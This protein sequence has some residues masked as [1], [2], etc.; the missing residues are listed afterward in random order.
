MLS[1]TTTGNGRVHA[2]P[3]PDPE[4]PERPQERV[5]LRPTTEG[6]DRL[7]RLLLRQFLRR[8]RTVHRIRPRLS[9]Y[10]WLL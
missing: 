2:G 7:V 4:V 5:L 8:Q 6:A 3:M 9:T 1:T 10:C